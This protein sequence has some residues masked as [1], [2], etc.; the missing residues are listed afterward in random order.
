MSSTFYPK[1]KENLLKG[2]IDVV[3][4]TVKIA[5]VDTGTYTYSSTHELYSDLSG[6]VGTPVALT[7]KTVTDGAI[8]GDDVTFNSVTGN[9]VEAIVM[10]VD[11]GTPATSYLISY[12]D[13]ITN[14]P[15]I[16]NG[17][18]LTIQWDDGLNIAV[19]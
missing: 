14:S 9:T 13:D 3:N 17:G 16:P 11:S 10:Y 15:I 8:G 1:A 4:D 6:V 18:D 2:N 7:T 5:M 12:I 19:L